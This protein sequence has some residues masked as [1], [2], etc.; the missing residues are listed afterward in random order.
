MQSAT[1]WLQETTRSWIPSPTQF[2]GA[3]GHRTEIEK[4][5]DA[6]L[7]IFRMFEIG[8]LRHGTGIYHHS[9]A[10]YLVS[11]KGSQPISPWTALNNVKAALQ[12]RFPYTTIVVR[13]PAVVCRFND[14][15]V[16][17]VPGYITPSGYSIPDPTGGWM[18]TH[19][20]EH[21]TWVNDVNRNLD[22]AAKKLARQVKIWKYQ[23]N[24][25]VSSCYLEM[26]AAKHIDGESSYNPVWDLYLTFRKLQTAQLGAMN[27]PTGLGS[28]FTATSSDASRLDA[29]SK[30]NTAVSR[31]EKAKDYYRNDDHVSAIGQLKLLLGV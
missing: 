22:G 2:D 26:R 31:A 7:G 24:V 8:S 3:R 25:P 18:I 9:D 5:L 21:N 16:E 1:A 13:Q 10:D 30:L 20:E 28:R 4:K 14:G 11:L 29:L 19:P 12:E 23:R 15:D 17:V 27:D 6:K